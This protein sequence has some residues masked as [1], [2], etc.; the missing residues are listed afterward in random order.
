MDAC[1]DKSSQKRQADFLILREVVTECSIFR[2]DPNMDR[3]R[4]K[5]LGYQP[6]GDNLA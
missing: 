1:S 2:L 3:M 6:L 4:D 5:I